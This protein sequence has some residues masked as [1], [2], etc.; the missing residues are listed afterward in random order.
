M[1]LAKMILLAYGLLMILGG[2]MGF[3]AGSK[4]SLIMGLISGAIVLMALYLAD[5]NPNL[6]YGIILAT[7]ALLCIVFVIRLIKT[8]KMMPSA[9]LLMLSL[10]A[11][12]FSI[13]YFLKK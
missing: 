5:N 12:I 8:Q 7:T 13:M 10:I 3:K 4:V 1:S 11:F 9:G 2:F 6:G